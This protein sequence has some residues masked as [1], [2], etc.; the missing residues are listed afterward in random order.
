VWKVAGVEAPDRGGEIEPLSGLRVAG[1]TV[2][3]GESACGEG[4]R[5]KL[6]DCRREGTVLL[7]PLAIMP[8]MLFSLFR[9][10]LSA[11]AASG[12]TVR[13]VLL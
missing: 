8:A 4:L 11:R 6:R 1:V 10:G 5:E 12:P 3:D 13:M 2:P 9:W 7:L